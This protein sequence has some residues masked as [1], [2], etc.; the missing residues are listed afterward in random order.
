MDKNYESIYHTEEDKNWWFVARRD[1]LLKLF[2]KYKIRK[3]ARILDIGCAGGSFLVQLQ[4]LGYTNVYAL[5]YSAEAIALCKQR[6]IENAYVMDGHHPEFPAETFDL[7]I[8]SDSLEHLKEDETALPNWKTILKPGG[9]A[10]IFVPAFN[11]LWTQHDDIN[12]HYRRYTKG[13][14]ENK[15]KR[16]GFKI[17]SAGYWNALFFIPTAIIRLLTKLMPKKADKTGD[18]LHLPSAVNNM[19]IGWMKIENSIGKVLPYPF[20][21]STY[22]IV[23]K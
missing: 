12:Y 18:I 10:F 4:K 9:M 23:S 17:L 7:I 16:A 15:S 3:D 1:M 22:V 6:G 21:V 13:D 8:A 11:F 2:E 20:G 19:L 5:D 14:L